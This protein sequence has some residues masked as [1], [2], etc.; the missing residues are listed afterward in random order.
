MLI[1]TKICINIF[2][3]IFLPGLFHK[4]ICQSGVALNPWAEKL[5]PKKTALKYLAHLDCKERDP[6]AIVAFLRGLDCGQLLEAQQKLLTP[7][8]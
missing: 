7:Q 1:N 5:E 8:V 2:V 6:K 4:A 3:S